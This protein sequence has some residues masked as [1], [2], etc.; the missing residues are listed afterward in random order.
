MSGGSEKEPASSSC[1]PEESEALESQS[2]NSHHGRF[3][4]APRRAR[5]RRTRFGE[6]WRSI[7]G[8]LISGEFSSSNSSDLRVKIRP[9]RQA[10]HRPRVQQQ[11]LRPQRQVRPRRQVH[12][13]HD[14]GVF[15]TPVCM[16]AAM[17]FEA[18]THVCSNQP[19]PQIRI[20]NHSLVE[21]TYIATCNTSKQMRM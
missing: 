21:G 12:R 18:S 19:S 8:K 16:C 17:K 13:Q 2:E 6:F 10:H 11:F 4:P 7:N 14:C 5:R 15:C 3:G 1:R 9:R 20:L